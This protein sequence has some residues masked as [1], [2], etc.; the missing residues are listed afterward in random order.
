MSV[1]E[2]LVSLIYETAFSPE[3]W[4]SLLDKLA[5]VSG[6]AAGALF[7]LKED[8]LLQYKASD[9]ILPLAEVFVRE[10]AKDSRRIPYCLAHPAHGFTIAQD[11]FPQDVFNDLSLPLKQAQGF[12][13]E[14]GVVIPMIS[15]EF[16]AL[17]F[18]R[19][20]DRGRHEPQDLARLNALYPH[21]ARAAL[22]ACRLGLER[23]QATVS[24]L[25]ALGIPAAALTRA[26][27]IL[28]ANDLLDALSA[29]IRPAAFG[30]LLLSSP[31][32]NRLFQEA[33]AQAMATSWP[34][35]RSIPLPAEEDRPPLVVHVL[36]L[37]RSAGDVLF[38]AEIL[39]CAN[40]LKPSGFTPSPQ[41]LTA[42]FDLT[43]AEA[44]LAAALAL[45]K[46]LKAVAEETHITFG[47]ARSYLARIFQ[48][49]GTNRQSQLVTLLKSTHPL[50]S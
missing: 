30:K 38:G 29:S 4:P 28:A 7:I 21:L 32:A 46:P 22:I 24:T 13:S 33:V 37:F 10:G 14:V 43:P 31:A 16:A 17:A 3:R 48:K 15:G 42:L 49:T 40:I 11:Y 8:R 19:Q 6:S 44:R 50:A 20:R 26:G 39:V 34:L 23:A 25:A 2:D 27:R 41:I 5:A 9:S 35:V 12:D 45:G 47:T 36:P 1:S 18:E